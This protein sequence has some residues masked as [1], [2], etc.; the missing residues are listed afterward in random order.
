MFALVAYETFFVKAD[1]ASRAEFERLGLSPFTYEAAG[2]KRT[3][4]AY[5]T[6]PADALDSS[7][8]LCEWAEKGVAASVRAEEARKP[9]KV[10]KN[11]RIS[12]I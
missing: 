4:M 3:V 1:E 6:V 5:F 8:L 10:H 9:K 11:S 7:P 2:G 12:R